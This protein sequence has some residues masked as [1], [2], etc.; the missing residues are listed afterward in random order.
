MVQLLD[1]CIGMK[2]YQ[3]TPNAITTSMVLKPS[4][5]MLI[6]TKFNIWTTYTIPFNMKS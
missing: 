5:S 6:I 4:A 2:K 1:D 3:Q